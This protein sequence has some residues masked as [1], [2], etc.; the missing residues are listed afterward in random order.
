MTITI[1]ENTLTGV[2]R[3]AVSSARDHGYHVDRDVALSLAL[4][5][6]LELPDDTLFFPATWAAMEQPTQ[7]D[8]PASIA[9]TREVAIAAGYGHGAQN[10]TA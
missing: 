4:A 8:D 2:V 5:D 7:L 10:G 3:A 6:L 9:F 1:D